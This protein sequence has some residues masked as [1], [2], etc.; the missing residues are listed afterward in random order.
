MKRELLNAMLLSAMFMLGGCGSD[1]YE[2]V[3]KD[4]IEAWN[5]G[6]I[7]RIVK[8]VDKETKEA[9]QNQMNECIVSKSD[10]VLNK[11]LKEYLKEVDRVWRDNNPIIAS[12]SIKK[13]SEKFNEQL[14]KITQ[15]STTS[16]YDKML[17]VGLLVL[18]QVESYKEVKSDTSPVAYKMLAFMLS[19]RMR[20]QSGD[21]FGAADRYSRNE[22][23]K[24]LILEEMKKNNDEIISKTEEDC[25]QEIFHP[26]TLD[27]VNIIET[28]ELSADRKDI[29]VELIYKDKRSR[30]KHINVEKIAGK[31]L[32]TTKL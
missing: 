4:Y 18:D 28:K 6:S 3:T 31:W 5:E 8:L 1:G 19:N 16:D 21:I 23:F 2:D 14:K 7:E 29:K 32:V 15:D 30:K 12:K 13:T 24:S 17:Q 11:K 9:I 27:K 26:D 10:P 20:M 22:Y 25:K